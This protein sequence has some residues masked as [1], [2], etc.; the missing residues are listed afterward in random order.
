MIIIR[1]LFLIMA[2]AHFVCAGIA[3][4]FGIKRT[5]HLSF[6]KE[7]NGLWYM[8]FPCWPFWHENL[9]MIGGID[10]LCDEFAIGNHMTAK[11]IVS[12]HILD[13]PRAN[14]IRLDR[15]NA[16]LK[17]GAKYEILKFNK[18]KVKEICLC[19]MTLFVI[20][21][22]PKYIYLTSKESGK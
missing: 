1:V 20:G 14:S 7:P 8:D 5:Y 2:F 18:I 17:S 11:I 6:T 16:S 13:I 19:Q 3:D 15:K 10:D 22:W 9:M 4:L 12:R 21:W